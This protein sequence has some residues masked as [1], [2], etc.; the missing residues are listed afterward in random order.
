MKVKSG[1]NRRA[2]PWMYVKNLGMG[3]KKLRAMQKI[4]Q[5][6][7]QDALWL[8]DWNEL[9]PDNPNIW[10][11]NRSK[12]AAEDTRRVMDVNPWLGYVHAGVGSGLLAQLHEQ[13]IAEIL[14]G[15]TLRHCVD[16]EEDVG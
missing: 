1:M 14:D 7:S 16:G 13:L 5:A 2:L 9:E 8:D 12:Q 6:R 15:P 4:S 11:E 10:Q 3:G